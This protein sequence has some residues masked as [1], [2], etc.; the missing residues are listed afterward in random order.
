MELANLAFI[1]GPE[2]CPKTGSTFVRANYIYFLKMN[3]LLLIA[4]GA[5]YRLGKFIASFG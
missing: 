3:F 1:D 2:R 4:A 5:S